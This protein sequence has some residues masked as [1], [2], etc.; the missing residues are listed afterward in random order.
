MDMQELRL[1]C[2]EI[3]Q[4]SSPQGATSD[5]IL[6][7]AREYYGW[8][9]DTPTGLYEVNSRAAAIV[10]DYTKARSL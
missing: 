3:A 2:L 5:E 7:A 4:L 8:V 1:R 9:A 10:E 6:R